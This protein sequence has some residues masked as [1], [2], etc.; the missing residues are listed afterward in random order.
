MRWILR[1]GCEDKPHYFKIV[2]E[3]EVEISKPRIEI[4]IDY[5]S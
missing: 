3:K 2:D 5:N 1:H 4:T